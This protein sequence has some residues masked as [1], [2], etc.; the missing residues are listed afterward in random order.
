[1]DERR[2][3][4]EFKTRGYKDYKPIPVRLML[5]LYPHPRRVEYVTQTRYPRVYSTRGYT[6]G[7]SHIINI[8]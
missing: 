5:N 8:Y 2:D 4:N 6:R 3:G 7:H 1:V